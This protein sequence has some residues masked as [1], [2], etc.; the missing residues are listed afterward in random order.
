MQLMVKEDKSP[1]PKEGES[2]PSTCA[3][4]VQKQERDL[5]NRVCS[6]DQR[7]Q[8]GFERQSLARSLEENVREG[9]NISVGTPSHT[10]S[11]LR[12]KLPACVLSSWGQGKEEKLPVLD[13]LTLMIP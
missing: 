10:V 7:V 2:E 1:H 12:Q 13:P 5:R 4:R 3:G 8:Q 6:K 11:A 9:E